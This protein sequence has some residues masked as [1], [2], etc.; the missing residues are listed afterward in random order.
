MSREKLREEIEEARAD[1]DANL[2]AY[3]TAR[4]DLERFHKAKREAWRRYW[5]LLR[6]T[7]EEPA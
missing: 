2:R 7:V 5:R 4:F 1:Y 6:Q 3:E